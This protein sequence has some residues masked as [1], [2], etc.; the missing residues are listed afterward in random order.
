MADNLLNELETNSSDSGFRCG[1]PPKDIQARTIKPSVCDCTG[2]STY[3]HANLCS[4]ST[5]LRAPLG[6][7]E[8]VNEEN[9]FIASYY[10]TGGNRGYPESVKTIHICCQ[11]GQTRDDSWR[12]SHK[13]STSA[14]YATSSSE[15]DGSSK[16]PEPS[17]KTQDFLADQKR[18][19]SGVEVALSRSS[20]LDT[21]FSGPFPS[22]SKPMKKGNDNLP[23]AQPTQ[24]SKL[25]SKPLFTGE[26]IV[27]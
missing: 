14:P 3:I 23:H 12:K 13:L 9:A 5:L 21:K 27:L 26:V 2:T 4:H 15:S 20:L 6:M 19:K 11:C 22:A 17:G 16:L 25:Q 8:N 18:L 7:I 1:A 24:V 10:D